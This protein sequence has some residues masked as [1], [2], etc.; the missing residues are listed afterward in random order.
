M[1]NRLTSFL[2]PAVMALGLV[3]GGGG[4]GD[5]AADPDAAAEPDSNVEPPD[6]S[7]GSLTIEEAFTESIEAMCA[8][9]FEC[10]DSFPGTPEDFTASYGADEAACF[11]M[12][13]GYLA[14]G[15]AQYQ[16]SVD[17][18]RMT[19]DPADAR[20]CLDGLAGVTCDQYW[21]GNEEPPECDTTFVGQ[22]ADGGTCTMSDDCANDTSYC[23]E[24]TSLCTAE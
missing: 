4:G 21:N 15:A 24:T 13:S 16:A 22:V 7:G 3:A 23:D 20:T 19:Y 14:A 12:Y 17:A 5:D 1:M 11:A 10:Q 2:V 18:G 9:A 6:A 8:K